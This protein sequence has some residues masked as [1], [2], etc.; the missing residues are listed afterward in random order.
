MGTTLTCIYIISHNVLKRVIIR[1]LVKVLYIA[2]ITSPYCHHVFAVLTEHIYC[3]V[4]PVLK[5]HPIGHKNMVSQDRWSLVTGSFTLK[6]RTFHQ[7]SMIF[8]DR[9]SLKTGFTVFELHMLYVMYMYKANNGTYRKK[10]LY[11]K[12][13]CI[14]HK[15]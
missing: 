13:S 4:E 7:I 8:Q 9:W 6:C 15:T 10:H 2:N 5:D 12:M 11:G 14:L 1:L 3:T